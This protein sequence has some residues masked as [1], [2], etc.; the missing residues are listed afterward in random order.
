M[1]DSITEGYNNR[2]HRT[3]AY[4]RRVRAHSDHWGLVVDVFVE[5]F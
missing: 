3:L 1:R 2:N 5:G 4:S